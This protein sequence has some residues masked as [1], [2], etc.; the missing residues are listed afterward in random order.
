MVLET[1][2]SKLEELLDIMA[3]LRRDTENLRSIIETALEEQDERA[4][5]EY[6]RTH[7]DEDE[8]DPEEGGD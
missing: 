4:A 7:D 8:A 2:H 6:A 5:H 3:D 1:I